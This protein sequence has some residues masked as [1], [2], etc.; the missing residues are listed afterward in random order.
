VAFVKLIDILLGIFFNLC[1]TDI[2]H[3]NT[4][5]NVDRLGVFTELLLYTTVVSLLY[6]TVLTPRPLSA[7]L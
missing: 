6:C 7:V 4:V 1:S 3:R 2:K 5:N